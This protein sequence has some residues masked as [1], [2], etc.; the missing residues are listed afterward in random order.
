[1]KSWA[2]YAASFLFSP[3]TKGARTEL[4]DLLAVQEG[5]GQRARSRVV[6]RCVTTDAFISLSEARRIVGAQRHALDARR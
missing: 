2:D 5:R 4:V 3:S 6:L 1:M